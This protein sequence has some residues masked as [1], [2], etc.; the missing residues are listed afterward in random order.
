MKSKPRGPIKPEILR[1]FNI[2]ILVNKNVYF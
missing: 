2:I 1:K